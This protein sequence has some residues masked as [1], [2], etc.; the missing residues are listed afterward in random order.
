[1]SACLWLYALQRALRRPSQGAAEI[2][3][4]RRDV[5]DSQKNSRVPRLE[6]TGKKIDYLLGKRTGVAI[7]T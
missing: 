1:M 7:H 5:F 6:C 2:A 3:S 4:R